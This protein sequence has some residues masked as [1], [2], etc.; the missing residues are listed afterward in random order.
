MPRLRRLSVLV[1]AGLARPASASE[2]QHIL[3]GLT[4]VLL[5][6]AAVPLGIVAFAAPAGQTKTGFLVG[7][8]AAVLGA[9]ASVA[10]AFS[11][12]VV[13]GLIG[14]AVFIALLLRTQKLERD[15][16]RNADDS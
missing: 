11:D 10:A 6:V 8:V 2:A 14:L 9:L 16:Q 7:K 4:A 3:S 12:A 15:L 13:S 1:T 5:L